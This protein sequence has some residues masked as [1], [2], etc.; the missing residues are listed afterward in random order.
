[1]PL[2]RWRPQDFLGTAQTTDSHSSADSGSTWMMRN[3]RNKRL[4]LNDDS[5]FKKF[6]FCSSVTHD[7]FRPPAQGMEFCGFIH[8]TSAVSVTVSEL[9]RDSELEMSKITTRCAILVILL[10]VT[11]TFSGTLQLQSLQPFCYCTSSLSW[12]S[13]SL[14]PA[15]ASGTH[16]NM[17]PVL[18]IVICISDGCLNRDPNGSLAAGALIS[19]H[20]QLLGVC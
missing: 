10:G 17:F 3:L 6:D 2:L 8:N 16:S 1:M 19:A 14:F 18:V 4:P 11:P 20:M 9:E 13:V 5:Q 15:T 12:V 7:V